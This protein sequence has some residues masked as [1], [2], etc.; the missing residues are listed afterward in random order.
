MARGLSFDVYPNKT[1]WKFVPSVKEKIEKPK[2]RIQQ[3]MHEREERLQQQY[4]A[5]T[6]LRLGRGRE[7]EKDKS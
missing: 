6:K 3:K 4:T 7:Y 2:K 1:E 5:T